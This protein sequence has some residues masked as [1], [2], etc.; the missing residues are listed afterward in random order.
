[1]ETNA[2]R[3]GSLSEG[4]DERKHEA[5]LRRKI[6][7]NSKCYTCK[8]RPICHFRACK[9]S[10]FCPPNLYFFDQMLSKLTDDKNFYTEI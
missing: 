10:H 1:M 5:W 2:N 6:L 7:P 4:I 9:K 8:K 3:F